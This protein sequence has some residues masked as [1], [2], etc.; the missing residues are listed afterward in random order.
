MPAVARCMDTATWQVGDVRVSRIDELALPAD[1]AAW[2]LPEAT[3]ELIANSGP[4]PAGA[5]AGDG[6]LAL[7]VQTF[8]LRIGAL[9]VL[10]D[11]GVG[12]GK[13]RTNPAWSNL[14]TP[15]LDRLAAADFAPED[16]D[17]VVTT[18]LHTDHV[19]WNTRW[20]GSAWIPTFPN[21]AYLV[22]RDEYE[23]WTGQD[24]D[25]GRRQLFV[26]SVEPIRASGH[27]RLLDIPAAGLEVAPGLEVV[28]TPGH[29]PG[30]VAV[31]VTSGTATAVISGDCLHHP[32]Q[33]ARPELNSS[34]DI[35]PAQAMRSRRA[36]LDH[37]ADTGGLLLGTH[38]P[39][40]AAGTVT[41]EAE[42][43]RLTLVPPQRR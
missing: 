24:L 14:N 12:N 19:G 16:V 43:Y 10:V 1:T 40:P 15:F 7:S 30:H 3:P 8:A 13:Q 26:D 9:R 23:W 29:T 32:L 39:P 25:A 28:R 36:L 34:A 21:A 42:H 27:L 20:N 33:L 22:A 37:L 4:L 6:R 5:L 17:L 41:R 11:T 35:D 31:R 2:L 38:V 18:H